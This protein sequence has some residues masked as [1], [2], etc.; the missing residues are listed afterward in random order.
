METLLQDLRYGLRMLRKNPAFTAVGV[1]TLALGIGINSA[2]FSVVNGVL[3]QPLPYKDP[4]RLV[5]VNTIAREKGQTW[6]TS[7]VDFRALREGNHTFED[8]SAAYG[9]SLNLTGS[10]Q[11]E[12]IR[13]S[14]VSYEYFATLGVTPILGRTF[15]AE[16]EQWGDH[17]EIILSE[18]FWRT[19]LGA[20]LNV[21]GKT[22]R[23]NGEQYNIVGVMPRSLKLLNSTQVWIPMAWA[24]DDSLNNRNNHFVNLVGRL[25][26][27][28]GQQQAAADLNTIMHSIAKQFPENKGLEVSLQP[29]QESLVGNIRLALLVL[30]G[31]VGFVLLIACVNL[32]NLLLARAAGRRKEIALRLSLGATNRRLFRQFLTESLLLSLGGGT[33]GLALAYFYLRLLPLAHNVLPSSQ[34]IRLDG[35]V[36]AFTLAISILTGVLFGI[37]PALQNSHLR[38]GATLKEGGRNSETAGKSWLRAALVVGEVAVSLVLLI[39]AGLTITS[40]VRLLH[41]DPGFDPSHVLT[42]AVNLPKSY[43]AGSD[44]FAQGAPPRVAIFFQELFKRLQAVPGVKSAGAVSSLP[45]RGEVWGKYFVPM[46]R[47]LPTSIDKVDTVQFR[48]VGGHYFNSMG[49][50]LVKGR[51]LDQRDVQNSPPVVVINETVSRKYWPGS[52]PLGKIVTLAPPETLI[53][54]SSIPPG[55]HIPRL[56]IVGVVADVHHGGLDKKATPTVYGSFLQTDWASAMVIT[57]R[58]EGDPLA[59]V[60]AARNQLKQLDKNLPMV[61]IATMNDIMSNS[62]AQPRLE[63]VLLGLFGA[64]A[65]T[66]AAVGIYG[67]MSYAVTQRTGE[68]GVRMALGADRLDV[69]KMIIGQGLRMV[70]VGISIGLALAFAIT[71]VLARLLFGVSPT[72]P[73]TFV[74]IVALLT[75]I[76]LFA[77]YIPARRATKVD[78]MVALRYE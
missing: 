1:I 67:V 23:L 8:L 4:G 56:T 20:D 66:L 47:A 71:R 16:E 38:L 24:P 70:G 45:L 15:I 48:A 22:L 11:P 26:A 37:V 50:S 54:A 65:V 64:L 39:G 25:R 76:G 49:I 77:C 41:V 44:P 12:L 51:L 43:S 3:L 78:P 60:S 42:F 61:S 40:F 68:I 13:A 75:L 6:S 34:Q 27:R 14:A 9:R 73:L 32:A 59:F 63:S 36:L 28:V 62:V 21:S 10:E 19:H 53:P 46:D 35:W 7:P 69:L 52:E 33:I 31:A 58:S 5:V 30:L 2:M 74:S 72:D 18:E 17:L 57:I 55:Y 29:L